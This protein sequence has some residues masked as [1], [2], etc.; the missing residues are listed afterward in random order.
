[1]CELDNVRLLVTKFA[2][3][4]RF[5]KDILGFKVTWGDSSSGYVSFEAGEGKEFA[6]FDRQA[7]AEAVGTTV[8]PAVNQA[9]D[10][11]AL[12]FKVEEKLEQ[13]VIRLQLQ[14]VDI[15]SGV[16]DRPDWGIKTIHLR[17]PDGNLIEL[18]SELSKDKWN[19]NLLEEDEKFT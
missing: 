13:I 9:Q 12:I 14:N 2:D 3:C 16:Q 18:F 4:Y 17:D 8:L 5:Y 6:I 15:V 19:R 10:R 11:F 7:M 1:M